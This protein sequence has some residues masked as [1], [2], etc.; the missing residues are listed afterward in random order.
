[1][2]ALLQSECSFGGSQELQ[3]FFVL[4]I[5]DNENEVAT[6]VRITFSKLGSVL[7]Y[8]LKSSS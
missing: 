1:M 2:N 4:K 8:P 5:G 6:M 3:R 7:D